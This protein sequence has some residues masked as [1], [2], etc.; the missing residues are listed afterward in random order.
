M[1]TGIDSTIFIRCQQ[2][3]TI[4]AIKIKQAIDLNENEIEIDIEL[5]GKAN[6]MVTSIQECDEQRLMIISISNQILAFEIKSINK[7]IN[8]NQ[9]N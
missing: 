7:K 2:S 6:S 5:S 8:K 4:I 3:Q 1:L 9:F